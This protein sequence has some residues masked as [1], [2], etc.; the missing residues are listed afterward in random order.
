MIQIKCDK[1]KRI[2]EIIPKDPLASWDWIQY[3]LKHDNQLCSG[4]WMD[5]FNKGNK[6]EKQRLL[7]QK[8]K[9][10]GEEID[11]QMDQ[12]SLSRPWPDEDD[13]II[14]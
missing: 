3:W 2:L 10:T 6:K 4:C 9:D 8:A 11:I 5:Q 14:P 12:I 7:E 13:N 1:C